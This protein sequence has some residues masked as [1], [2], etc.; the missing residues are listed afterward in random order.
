MNPGWRR[1]PLFYVEQT[2][3]SLF[4]DLILPPPFEDRRVE[5]LLAP[6]DRIPATAAAARANLDQARAPLR[7]AV[8][9]LAD[10]DGRLATVAKEL[11]PLLPAGKAARLSSSASTAGK[12]LVDFRRWLE[13]EIPKMASDTAVGREASSS[14]C[15]KIA[16]LPARRTTGRD[17]P[18]RMGT[19]G[20]LRGGGEESPAR[21]PSLSLP[22]S[23]A[24]QIETMDREVAWVRELFDAGHPERAG[25]G[26]ELPAQGQTGLSRAARRPRGQ[27]RLHRPAPARS[28]RH[29]LDRRA[30][31]HGRL[32]ISRLRRRAA[33]PDRARKPRPLPATRVVVGAPGLDPPPLLR[34]GRQRRHRLLQ[35]GAD[36]AGRF[37]RRSAEGRER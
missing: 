2:L 32:L 27:Q 36:G 28:R 15:A 29:R 14:S 1:N 18:A 21:P 26:E 13:G 10:A 8:A 24:A 33:H 9:A 37:V 25:V 17:G 11:A 19:R 5:N 20:G 31:A 23:R 30:I 3:G 16:L 34:L 6:L 4:E 7:L 12:A 35:R 22:A